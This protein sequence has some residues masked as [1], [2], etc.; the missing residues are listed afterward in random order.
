LHHFIQSEIVRRF[1]DGSILNRDF[2]LRFR[3][4]DDDLLGLSTCV[5]LDHDLLVFN[6]DD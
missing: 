2:H 6:D 4:V 5:D 3:L 1:L